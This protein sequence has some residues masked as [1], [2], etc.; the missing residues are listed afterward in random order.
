MPMLGVTDTE[1]EVDYL[2]AALLPFLNSFGRI[3]VWAEF[4]ARALRRRLLSKDTRPI[5]KGI[6]YGRAKLPQYLS[7]RFFEV[8][9]DLYVLIVPEVFVRQI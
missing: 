1:Y 5:C 4:A 2:C 7:Q 9:V 6:S 3:R 8:L